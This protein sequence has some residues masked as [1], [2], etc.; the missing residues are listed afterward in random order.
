MEV[1]LLC[2]GELSII[3]AGYLVYYTLL[4]NEKET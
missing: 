1:K 3:F 2:D 4:W